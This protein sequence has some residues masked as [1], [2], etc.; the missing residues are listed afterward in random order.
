MA[1]IS[2][3]M[4]T[5]ASI[6]VEGPIVSFDI[7]I[8]LLLGAAL[9]GVIGVVVGTV[10]GIKAQHNP[11]LEAELHQAR[12]ALAA[13]RL[14]S[15]RSVALPLLRVAGVEGG[16]LGGEVVPIHGTHAV[17]EPRPLARRN[18]ALARC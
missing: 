9:G 2:A 3:L 17:A 5:V 7:A 11:L 6:G 4:I 8:G 12:E 1:G 18:L 16:V 13:I 10:V 15:S 14:G